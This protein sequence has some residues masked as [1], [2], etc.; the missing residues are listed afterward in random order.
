VVKVVTP[1]GVPAGK[2]QFRLDAIS[3]IN[4]DDD[5]TE[6]PTVDLEVEVTE[7][8]KKAFPW[9]LIAAA[10]GAVILIVTLTWLLWPSGGVEVPDVVGLDVAEATKKFEDSKFKVEVT[11]QINSS[12]GLNHV[13]AQD[14]QGKSTAKEGATVMLLVAAQKPD[15]TK[16][17]YEE[18]FNDFDKDLKIA[19]SNPK[20]D[21]TP[22]GKT[23]FLGQFGSESV[24]LT[25][26]KLPPHKTVTVMFD[27]YILRTWDG[28]N[29]GD[30]PDVWGL[31]LE[32]TAVLINTSFTIGNTIKQ[33]FACKSGEEAAPA[34]QVSGAVGPFGAAINSL[35]YNWGDSVYKI[36]RTFAHDRSFLILTFFGDLKEYLPENRN[37]NNE[38]WGLDNM[39]IEAQ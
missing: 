22:N 34:C 13:F 33:R 26:D 5:F 11:R 30:G 15:E 23:R 18:N 9:R 7:A 19:W 8:P 6:G 29:P 3:V 32:D 39:R 4:P 14:P 35:G 38:S 10:A 28:E 25:L 36:K 12:V 1:P 24:K 2:Y 37:T 17:V 20:A 27:L 16:V 21:V 31:K